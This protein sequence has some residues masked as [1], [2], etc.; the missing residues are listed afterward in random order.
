MTELVDS[1]VSAINRRLSEALSVMG[2]GCLTPLPGVDLW[3]LDHTAL[4]IL[5]LA[6][7]EMRTMFDRLVANVHAE[8]FAMVRQALFSRSGHVDLEFRVS[9]DLATP[10]RTVRAR[11]G[12]GETGVIV[13]EDVTMKLLADRERAQMIER[14]SEASQLEAL[15]TLAGGIAHEIN[16]P[17]QFIGDNLNFIRDAIGGLSDVALAADR[18]AKGESTWECVAEAVAKIPVALLAKESPVATQQA[19]DGVERIGNIV[20]AIREFCY[21]SSKSPTPL[22]LNHLIEIAMTVTRN[23]WKYAAQM[24]LN[25][26]EALPVIMAIEGEIYQ[27][28]VNLIINSIYAIS[29]KKQ[30]GLGR[31]SIFTRLEGPMVR[32]TV[33]DNGIGI[34]SDRLARIFDMF[35]TTKPT[36]EGTG[37]G[38]AITQAIVLRHG[39]RISVES[40]LG[41]GASFHILLPIDGPPSEAKAMQG[42]I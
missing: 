18:A 8:D 21:P 15:G 17:A 20:Q 26:D 24:E 19:I 25:L 6:A 38:L 4:R 28:L 39:G 7:T 42:D 9:G 16:N 1:D 40:Q 37:Q 5:G 29:E 27:I 2:V 10:W 3:Q 41:E 13:L 33:A 23:K 14:I 12:E 11:G 36:G 32:L 22:S 30:S 34:P 35:Y 31:I